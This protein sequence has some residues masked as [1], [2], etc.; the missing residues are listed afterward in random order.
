ME[1]RLQVEKAD[2]K[3][4]GREKAPC[5]LPTSRKQWEWLRLR[6][7]GGAGVGGGEVGRGLTPV[8]S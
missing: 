4:L 5:V 2:A 1:L 3:A 6:E 7:Q 8:L